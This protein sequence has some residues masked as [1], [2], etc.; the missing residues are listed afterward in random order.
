MTHYLTIEAV[1]Q[2]LPA[3]PKAIAALL[4]RHG[5][6]GIPKANDRCPLAKYLKMMTGQSP[7]YISTVGGPLVAWCPDPSA[8]VVLPPGAVKFVLAFD[9]RTY[10]FLEEK[11]SVMQ[12]GTVLSPLGEEQA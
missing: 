3:D 2:S 5:V 1:V 7:I 9:A 11:V 4:W 6:Q 12:G 8:G 10:P